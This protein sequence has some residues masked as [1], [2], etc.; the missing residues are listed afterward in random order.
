MFKLLGFMIKSVF[1]VV[2][3][4]AAGSL[5]ELKGRTLS[6]HVESGLETISIDSWVHSTAKKI[7]AI[8]KEQ[9][10]AFNATVEKGKSRVPAQAESAPRKKENIPQSERQK[11][12]A[13]IHELNGSSLSAHR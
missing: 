3:V 11:L 12:R 4:L 7:S 5:I 1:V 2:L 9:T 8:A 13:L 6:E 10:Q